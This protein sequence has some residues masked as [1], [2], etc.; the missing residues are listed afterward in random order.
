MVF[1]EVFPPSFFE[2]DTRACTE[3][4]IFIVGASER[5]RETWRSR[6]VQYLN[7]LVEAGLLRDDKENNFF[8][9]KFAVRPPRG[10]EA[11]SFQ[12]S[13]FQQTCRA[14][15]AMKGVAQVPQLSRITMRALDF[16]MRL[17][18]SY[19]QMIGIVRQ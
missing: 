2:I 11:Q 14:Q 12:Q 17:E 4:T 19:D 16:S 13:L 5:M 3:L 6:L 1:I 8:A 18:S 9:E 10:Q 7:P 15:W